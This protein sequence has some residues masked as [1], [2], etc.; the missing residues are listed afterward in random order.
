MDTDPHWA[1]VE[2]AFLQALELEPA[3]RSD[4]LRSL[5]GRDTSVAREVESLLAAHDRRG[6]VDALAAERR[7]ESPGVWEDH[8]GTRIGPYEVDAVLGRGGMGVVYRAHRADGQFQQEVALKVL[9][10]D[11]LHRRSHERFLAE[12]EILARLSH[13]NVAR[14]LDGG[15]DRRGRPYFAMELVEGRTLLAHCDEERLGLDARVRLFLTVCEAVQHAHGH[16]VVHRDLKPGNIL[17]TSSGT[18]KLLD[19]G[20]GKILEAGGGFTAET[21]VGFRLLTPAYAAPEQLRGAPANTASDIYQLGILLF[22]LLSG[23]HPFP[24]RRGAGSDP[25]A[26]EESALAPTRPSVAAT[27]AD[28]QTV[29]T[30]ARARGS[31]GEALGRGLRGD[32]DAIVLKALRPDPA[33]RYTSATGLADDLRRFLEHR[34][35]RARRDSRSYRARLFVRRNRSALAVS[36]AGLVGILAFT[37]GIAR[38][39]RRTALERDRARAVSDFMTEL[40]ETADPFRVNRAEMAVRDVLDDGL[41]RL[42]ADTTTDAR[43]RASLLLAIAESYDGLGLADGAT[44]AALEGLALLREADDVPPDELALATANAGYLLTVAGRFDEATPLLW[45]ADSLRA[46]AA[47]RMT[48]A[49]TAPLL[50]TLGTGWL[51]IGEPARASPYLEGA[52]NLFLSLGDAREEAAASLGS[53]AVV[54]RDLGNPDSAEVLY[55][56]A[57]SLREETW[58]PDH[59]FTANSLDPLG[60]LLLQSGQPDEAEAI[61][62]R[63]LE[64]RAAALPPDHYLIATTQVG[65]AKVAAARGEWARA[66]SLFG[67][68]LANYRSTFGPEHYSVGRLLNDRGIARQRGGR[69]GDAEADYRASLDILRDQYGL[70]HPYTAQVAVNLAWVSAVNGKVAESV[71]LYESAVPIL[72]ELNPDDAS[73]Y[74]HFTDHGIILCRQGDP[75]GEA[76]LRTAVEEL[77]RL[78]AGSDRDL[79]ARNA[80]GS[81]LAG[82]GRVSEAV[83]ILEGVL[84]A[85]GSRPEGD[86]YRAFAQATLAQIRSLEEGPGSPQFPPASSPSPSPSPS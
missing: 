74:G 68:A 38:E 25:L 82:L 49:T 51:R 19:F 6:L 20:I 63:S 1:E 80:L 53:L 75:A 34:P 23:A 41:E 48:A 47:D 57:L 4:F 40:F 31:T 52:A 85:T 78:S 9:P 35:V 58:G 50:R 46:T 33:H 7:A 27:S 70:G 17:V 2:A 8:P 54:R 22:E 66:D 26:W 65:L 30:R 28:P 24:E 15:V 56:H 79:R 55:R 72:R 64:I 14:L 71:A 69:H 77:R 83:P 44:D 76:P 32:L 39:G 18:P 59:L 84:A 29:S 13:P 21:Q 37:A 16:L 86:P 10:A 36:A 61:L 60:D 3:E 81:C 73:V 43:V 42:R 62:R 67:P 45:S 12:R 11:L 5:R